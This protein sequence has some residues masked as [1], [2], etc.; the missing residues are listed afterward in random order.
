MTNPPET[1]EDR[2]RRKLIETVEAFQL[3]CKQLDNHSAELLN[4]LREEKKE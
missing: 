1:E 2:K 4:V 3:L